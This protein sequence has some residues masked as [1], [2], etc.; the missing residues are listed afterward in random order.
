[1]SE[2]ILLVCTANQGRSAIAQALLESGLA[3]R[4][5]HDKVTVTSAGL[6][7]GGVSASPPVVDAAARRGGD[8]TAHSS[9]RLTAELVDEADVVVGLAREHV[10]DVVDLRPGAERRAFTLKGLVRGAAAVGPRPPGQALADYLSRITG[11]QEAGRHAH[12]G[13]DDDIADPYGRPLSA[14]E[15]TADEISALLDRLVAHFWP[16]PTADR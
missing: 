5:L 14:L 2:R 12:A 10:H 9:R 15:E 8:L 1:M 7:E 6:M 13:Q 16:G 11:Q 4:R 3:R